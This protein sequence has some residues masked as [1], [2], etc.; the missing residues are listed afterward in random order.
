MTY[1]Y[2]KV[3]VKG[4][5]LGHYPAKLLKHCMYAENVFFKPC[6]F[7]FADSFS[8]ILLGFS[9]SMIWKWVKQ[10]EYLLSVSVAVICGFDICASTRLPSKKIHAPIW[11]MVALK[12]H[13]SIEAQCGTTYLPLGDCHSKI[14]MKIPTQLLQTIRLSPAYYKISSLYWMDS[15]GLIP[16]IRF[17]W[18]TAS[19]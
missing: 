17:H 2:Y 7:S 8:T 5:D 10:N 13:L 14:N 3:K 19:S 11:S 15:Q 1:C 6:C 9:N 16:I 18:K 4:Q 12:I